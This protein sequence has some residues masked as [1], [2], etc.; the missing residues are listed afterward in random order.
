MLPLLLYAVGTVLLIACANIGSLMMARAASRQKEIAIRTSL[1]AGRTRIIRQLLTES[2]LLALLGGTLGV[3]WAFCGIRL[4][5]AFAPEEWSR[6][7]QAG[8]DLNVLAFTL[9]VSLLS[10]VLRGRTVSGGL[11][12]WPWPGTALMLLFR[13]S[14]TLREPRRWLRR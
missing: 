4:F 10:A 6:L 9:S 1:G 14:G 7:D 5:V 11:S 13:A 3:I 2:T 8:L 12:P